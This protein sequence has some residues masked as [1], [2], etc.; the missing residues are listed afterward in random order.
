MPSMHL[1]TLHIYITSI[2]I[3]IRN[4]FWHDKST[5]RSWKMLL[6]SKLHIWAN[7]M[8]CMYVLWVLSLKVFAFRISVPAFLYYHVLRNLFVSYILML[9]VNFNQT[10]QNSLWPFTP[11]YVSLALSQSVL[12]WPMRWFH[13]MIL[14]LYLRVRYIWCPWYTVDI[15][16]HTPPIFPYKLMADWCYLGITLWCI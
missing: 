14:P 8:H 6:K 12:C 3:I 13:D 11:F 1:I 9:R 7:R 10:E 4:N 5:L 15:I 2:I 16:I